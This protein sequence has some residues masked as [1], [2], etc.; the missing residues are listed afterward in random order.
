MILNTTNYDNLTL[1]M[2]NKDLGCI[3]RYISI[4][5]QN[6]VTCREGQSEE[7]RDE[8]ARVYRHHLRGAGRGAARLLQVARRGHR[9]R[10][11]RHGTMCR[12]RLLVPQA[13]SQAP[14][15]VRDCVRI[16]YRLSTSRK[17]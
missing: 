9:R 8:C 12:M 13:A 4:F 6:T 11:E 17:E 5:F 2:I 10:E 3:L 1:T 15:E 14:N 16:T 7:R